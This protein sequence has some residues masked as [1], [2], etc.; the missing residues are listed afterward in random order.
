MKKNI[1]S[2]LLMALAAVF[3]LSLQSC[4]DD[5]EIGMNL[6]GTWRGYMDIWNK[7]GGQEY[8]S[9]YSE[10]CF[11][12]DPFKYKSGDG[13]WVDYYQDHPWGPNEYVANHIQWRVSAQVIYIHFIEENTDIQIHN[14]RLSDNYFTGEIYLDNRTAQFRLQHTSSPYWDDYD[15]G[16]FYYGYAKSNGN[17]TP[18]EA[19][20][21]FLGT[22]VNGK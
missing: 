22:V 1:A 19:P 20:R 10:I 14:Y 18:P 15:Y 7:Y 3:T 12:T 13:Y 4:S 11:T 6:E 21:R 17:V 16:Y 9:T 5:Q 8:M 2:L